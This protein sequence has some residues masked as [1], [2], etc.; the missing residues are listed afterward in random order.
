MMT[1]VITPFDARRLLSETIKGSPRIQHPDAVI[2][3]AEF[4]AK[5]V[6]ETTDRIR[7]AG[8]NFPVND[9]E[10]ESAA[11]LHDIGY[12]FAENKYHHP[13]IGGDFLRKR[14]YPRIGKIIETHTYAPEAVT[15]LGYKQMKDPHYWT[16]TLWNQVLIDYASLHAGMPHEKISPDEKFRRFKLKRDETFQDLIELAEPRLRKEI[17]EFYSLMDGN[18]DALS[19]Y[20]FL[21]VGGEFK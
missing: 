10:M 6:Q 8:I 16:P 2:S 14:G 18:S 20:D 21:E 9:A 5:L 3:H 19:A 4:I 17:G 1:S 7:D 13:H 11:I 15:L 12:C